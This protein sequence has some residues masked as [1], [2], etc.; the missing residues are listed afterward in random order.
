MVQRLEVRE[1]V[2]CISGLASNRSLDSWFLT[3]DI[4]ALYQAL[5][6]PV[7]TSNVSATLGSLRSAGLLVD[8][9]DG[10]RRQW[11][12]TPEGRFRLSEILAEF[13]AEDIEVELRSASA[14]EFAL[15]THQLVPPEMAPSR[16]R[17]AITNLHKTSPFNRSVFLMTRFPD[18]DNADSDPIERVIP[19][20][21][22]V[23]SQHGLVL[24]LASEKQLDAELWGNIGG[25]IWAC[26][27]GIGLYET[28]LPEADD[29]NDNVLIELGSML[30]L[31]RSCMI[32]RDSATGPSPPTD[33]TAHIWRDVDLE[34]LAGLTDVTHRWFA[35]DLGLGECQHCPG[36]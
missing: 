1:S 22:E 30:T 32:I 23:T 29:I 20:L 25:Y 24:H 15:A 17:T 7:P 18:T 13:T 16:W 33:L 34:D 27:Y 21:R 6:V 36:A 8:R 3:S 14:P 5:R 2:L 31:G 35:S 9:P 19:T 28:R 12:T 4:D 26:R 11:S 10:N